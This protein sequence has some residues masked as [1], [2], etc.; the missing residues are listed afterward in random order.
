MKGIVKVIVYSFST[1]T[2]YVEAN[3]RGFLWDGNGCYD[4]T[5]LQRHPIR[6]LFHW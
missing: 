1:F 3:I 4:V 2:K 5:R 6:T